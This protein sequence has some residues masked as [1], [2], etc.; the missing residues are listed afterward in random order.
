MTQST[1]DIYGDLSCHGRNT[2]PSFIIIIIIVVFLLLP[3]PP[4]SYLVRNDIPSISRMIIYQNRKARKP[5]QKKNLELFIVDLTIHCSLFPSPC[6]SGPVLLPA[7]DAVLIFAPFLFFFSF[8]FLLF[9]GLF[10]GFVYIVSLFFHLI[11]VLSICFSI[12]LKK[13]YFKTVT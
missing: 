12:S 5:K 11:P 6:F 2:Y 4:P 8:L 13:H 9:V 1:S 10:I 3:L 7:S